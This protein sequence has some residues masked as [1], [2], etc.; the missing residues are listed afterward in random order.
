LDFMTLEEGDGITS[1]HLK[2]WGQGH[3]NCINTRSQGF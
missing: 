2:H 3:L 1:L